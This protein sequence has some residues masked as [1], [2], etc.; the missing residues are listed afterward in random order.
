[1]HRARVMVRVAFS[2][3]FLMTLPVEAAE[4]KAT[5]ASGAISTLAVSQTTT[6]SVTVTNTGTVTWTSSGPN[7]I[8]LSYHWY[9]AGAAPTSTPPDY[10]AV[11]WNGF[12]TDLPGP[13]APGASVTLTARIIAPAKAGTYTLKWDMLREYVT[14][15]SQVGVPTNDQTVTVVLRPVA[16][17]PVLAP[18]LVGPPPSD[19]NGWPQD[20][21]DASK[22]GWHLWSAPEP[23]GVV[24]WRVPVGRMIDS[25]PVVAPDGTI[26]IGTTDTSGQ[27]TS[28]K[29][30]GTV[31]WNIR[32]GNAQVRGT[33]AIRSDG[34]LVV[35]GHEKVPVL[36][37]GK[38]D[39][40]KWVGRVHL[41]HA[42]GW[43]LRVSQDFDIDGFP[44]SSPLLDREDNAYVLYS[45]GDDYLVKFTR[46]FAS[47]VVKAINYDVTRTGPVI[48]HYTT[49]M[50]WCRDFSALCGGSGFG[51]IMPSPALSLWQNLKL[52]VAP[53]FDKTAVVSMPTGFGS[54]QKDIPGITTAAVHMDGGPAYIGTKSKRVEAWDVTGRKNWE[55]QLGGY[56]VAPPALGHAPSVNPFPRLV[57]VPASDG[58]LYFFNRAAACSSPVPDSPCVWRRKIGTKFAGAPAVLS[59]G[60]GSEIVVIA[61]DANVLRAFRQD[62]TPL[63]SVQLD[64]PAYGSPAI[65]NGRIYVATQTSVYA[66]R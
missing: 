54:W 33:P 24:A 26:Y 59:I 16:E 45:Y 46:D 23:K 49:A 12:R 47:T 37:N 53:S 50:P 30:D 1:M 34:S 18:V 9:A 3:F 4:Y 39:R 29:S 28:I 32:L 57:Y 41:V 31:K 13:L 25:S 61:S 42:S 43:L 17:S 66:I 8:R 10:G 5:Y 62:G 63:W 55:G 38:F 44:P 64:S 21:G 56:P 14:Y 27:L 36:K 22:T 20:R 35:V 58:Y 51:P 48:P 19:S 60:G 2:V 52:V 11:V 15:F 40:D 65:V 7:P 6:V